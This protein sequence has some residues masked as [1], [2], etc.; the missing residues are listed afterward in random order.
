M[1]NRKIVTSVFQKRYY[2]RY[3]RKAT[4]LFKLNRVSSGHLGIFNSNLGF[5]WKTLSNILELIEQSLTY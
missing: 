3:N 5:S 4:I 1:L 2:K